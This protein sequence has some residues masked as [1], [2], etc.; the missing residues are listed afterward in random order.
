MPILIDAGH[1]KLSKRFQ[2]VVLELSVA[3]RVEC[4]EVITS[5]SRDD[6]KN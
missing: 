6:E 2:T 1:I 3:M 4:G 5:N